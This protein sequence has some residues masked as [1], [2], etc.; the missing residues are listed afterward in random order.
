MP[1]P[2]W[3][4]Q[5]IHCLYSFHCETPLGD[6]SCMKL[7]ELPSI[8]PITTTVW[9][10]MPNASTTLNKWKQTPEHLE[11]QSPAAEFFCNF[12][13][14][15]ARSP[16]YLH[17]TFS[18]FECLGFNIWDLERMEQLGLLH[19]SRNIESSMEVNKSERYYKGPMKKNPAIDDL[20]RWSS[21]LTS[22]RAGL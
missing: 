20:Y 21:L 7:T 17:R 8:S 16:L 2:R 12:Y 19:E 18:P 22:V 5:E 10:P 15:H 6:Q 4:L 1:I 11:E 3:Q 9:K 13:P 14:C